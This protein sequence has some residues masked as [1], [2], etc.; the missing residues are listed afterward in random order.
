MVWAKVSAEAE[1]KMFSQFRA[2]PFRALHCPEQGWR[3]DCVVPS[4][5]C[6]TPDSKQ[7]RPDSQS[8]PSSVSSP[9]LKKH[10]GQ[11][12]QNP[13]PSPIILCR[14][15]QYRFYAATSIKGDV[16]TQGY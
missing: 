11:R 10:L 4:S 5:C 1:R 6:L 7:P 12:A 13:F 16:L 15:G 14:F 8:L 2:K 9:F 3:K